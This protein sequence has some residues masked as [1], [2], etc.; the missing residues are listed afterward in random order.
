MREDL[1]LMPFSPHQALDPLTV[2]P[3]SLILENPVDSG[4]A[5]GFIT[6]PVQRFD[7]FEEFLVV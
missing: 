6:L 5:I 3:F 2:Y 7:P 4:A 1:A